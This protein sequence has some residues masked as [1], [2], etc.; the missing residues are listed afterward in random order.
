MSLNL[1]NR[2]LWMWGT[3]GGNVAYMNQTWA[4]V[5]DSGLTVFQNGVVNCYVEQGQ[6][7]GWDRD[8]NWNVQWHTVPYAIGHMISKEQYGF[9]TYTLTCRIPNWR[10]SWTAFWFVDWM[11]KSQGGMGMPPEIDVFEHFQK[12][13]CLSRYHITCTYNDGP[14]YEDNYAVDNTYCRL[15]PMD[16][17]DF[18]IQLVWKDTELQYIV[19]GKIVLQVLKSSMKHFPYKAMNI[20]IGAQVQNFQGKPALVKDDPFVIKS[21]TF[22]A[23]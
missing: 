22:D 1:I 5:F 9:G 15:Y 8:A 23:A 21:F 4:S 11:N 19:N 6:F 14:T 20:M 16:W 13:K 17:K 18:T 10:G 2:D 3:D 12:D 7:Q